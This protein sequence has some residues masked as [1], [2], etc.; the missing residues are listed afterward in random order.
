MFQAKTDKKAAIFMAAG[1]EEIEA[2]TVV[3]LL[4]RAGIPLAKV[5]ITDDLQVTS[6][7]EVTFMT[8]RSHLRGSFRLCGAGHPEREKG[9]LQSLQRRLP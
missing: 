6:S 4:Y 5:A 3:D 1:C 9:H 8:D 2:L 7:H